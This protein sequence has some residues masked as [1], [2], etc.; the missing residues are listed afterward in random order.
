MARTKVSSL[1]AQQLEKLIQ[2]NIGNEIGVAAQLYSDK[3]AAFE[4]LQQE[5]SLSRTALRDYVRDPNKD[6]NKRSAL[7]E[8]AKAIQK[9][10]QTAKEE[11]IF[12]ER[13]LE[14]KINSF[15]ILAEQQRTDIIMACE[16]H[17][18]HIV[19]F[20]PANEVVMYCIHT[21]ER[22]DDNEK[23][24]DGVVIYYTINNQKE[25]AMVELKL[26]KGWEERFFNEGKSLQ[27]ILESYYC[28]NG[29]Y[30]YDG[31]NSPSFESFSQKA[32]DGKTHL[33]KI[34]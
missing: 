1:T 29:P 33:L 28:V 32:F 10:L 15:C 26:H 3:R 18:H 22:K 25:V 9:S 23:T 4:Q 24:F 21:K 17:I 34:R 30:H 31:K 14:K 8:D 16:K 27:M 13:E 19:K 12:L 7:Q 6:P 20:D 2:S 11:I 5:E